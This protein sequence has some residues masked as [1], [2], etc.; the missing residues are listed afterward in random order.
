VIADEQSVLVVGVGGGASVLSTDAC[1]R[2]GLEVTPVRGD[3][4]ERLRGMGYGAGTSVANPIEIPF[5]PA[6]P[7]DAFARVIQP[8]IAE[9]RYSDIMLHFNVSSYFAFAT[10]GG[11]MLVPVIGAVDSLQCPGTRV[12]LVARNLDTA[13]PDIVQAM[14]D[15]ANEQRVSLFRT[16]DEATVAIAAA[17]RFSASR[18]AT[19]G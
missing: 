13:P 14:I 19:S 9:Q 8:I 12:A 17:Q 11:E 2:A 10:N 7:L 3:I 5:G 6:A 16:I 18:R 15:A 1:D 4:Q